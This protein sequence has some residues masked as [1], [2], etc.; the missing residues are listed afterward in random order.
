VVLDDGG[1]EGSPAR[2]LSGV[3]VFRARRIVCSY[4]V[5]C[6]CRASQT[7]S[8]RSIVRSFVRSSR[9]GGRAGAV[10]PFFVRGSLFVVV[11]ACAA[12]GARG[13]SPRDGR[14]RLGRYDFLAIVRVLEHD[15]DGAV[16]A[17]RR[18]WL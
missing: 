3:E 17:I 4:R 8:V 15:V 6:S 10:A 12:H 9:A 16:G 1:V 2:R 7:A 11:Q 14:G 13:R 18:D 5:V